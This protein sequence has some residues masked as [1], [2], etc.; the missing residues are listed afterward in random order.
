VI[1]HALGNERRY[2]ET[3]ERRAIC[4]TQI[5]WRECPMSCARNRGRRRCTPRVMS[6]GFTGL[7]REIEFVPLRQ[8]EFTSTL[9]REQKDHEHASALTLAANRWQ[10]RRACFLA[11]PLRTRQTLVDTRWT[12]VPQQLAVGPRLKLPLCVTRPS[13]LEISN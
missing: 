2:A 9:H 5:V 12:P 11:T 7:P 3:S 13:D 1:D 4:P 10:I 6:F 8:R